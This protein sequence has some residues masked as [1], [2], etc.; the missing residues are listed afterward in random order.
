[1]EDIEISEEEFDTALAEIEAIKQMR[2]VPETKSSYAGKMKIFIAHLA[3]KHP[4][5]LTEDYEIILE[6]LTVE[7]FQEFIVKKQREDGLG[8]SALSVPNF[9]RQIG[10]IP[11]CPLPPILRLFFIYFSI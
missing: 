11:T 8:F 1:M 10:K 2:L 6:D 9:P 3:E 7:F 4:E 5:V